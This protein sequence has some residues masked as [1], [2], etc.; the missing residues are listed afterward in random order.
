VQ[1]AVDAEPHV[2]QFTARLDVDIARP[3]IEGVLP[4]PVDD[5]DDVLVVRVELAIGL[6]EL[7]KLLEI[8]KLRAIVAALVRPLD[9]LG[10]IV[11]LDDVA[12]DVQRIREHPLDLE[13]QD[14][15][16]LLLPL[17][18]KGLGSRDDR[19]FRR[20][21]D[22]Q[23]PEALG[24]GARHDLGHRR[25]IDLQ[26]IDVVVR[27]SDLFSEPLREMLDMEQLVG[28]D[29]RFPLLVGEDR[30]RMYAAAV[31]ASLD[32]EPLALF[33][34][35]QPVGDER[36]HHLLQ[37]QAAFFVGD[38]GDGHGGSGKKDGRL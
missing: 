18:Q 5:V 25:E 34:R 9:R 36:I 38:C 23:D 19:L 1:N 22:R 29:R 6:A 13:L 2:A 30:Q 3:L 31:H 20:D 17:A 15:G 8:R 10:E 26:G 32:D 27:Q 24:I 14:P 37:G 16:K 35:N 7:D 21:L 11:E 33:A 12:I 4:Q 28:R